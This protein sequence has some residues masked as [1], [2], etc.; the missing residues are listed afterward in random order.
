[1]VAFF[2]IEIADREI[3]YVG[4]VRSQHHDILFTMLA[5]LEELDFDG[6]VAR[7]QMDKISRLLPRLDRP[8]QWGFPLEDLSEELLKQIF[9]GR[10]SL[11][12]QI[13][14]GASS[15]PSKPLDPLD[16][17]NAP[18]VLGDNR[19]A[20]QLAQIA[21]IGGLDGAIRALEILSDRDIEDFIAAINELRRDPNE[22]YAEQQQKK[23]DEIVSK[24]PQVQAAMMMG[25]FPN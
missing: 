21:S 19:I 13:H 5:Q 17:K 11:I 25:I 22:R 20:N 4:R 1:M 16:P 15:K 12:R 8:G 6:Q 18:I 10:D 24:N 2:Q 14:Q 7:S 9:I 23:W 3:C